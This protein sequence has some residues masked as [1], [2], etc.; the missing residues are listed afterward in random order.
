MGTIRRS[1]SFFDQ[2]SPTFRV[3][4]S[5]LLGFSVNLYLP[6]SM[7]P[8]SM[9][10][11]SILI[12]GEPIFKHRSDLGPGALA[13]VPSPFPRA[14]TESRVLRVPLGPPKGGG[15]NQGHFAERPLPC[16]P[17]P[18]LYLSLSFL[19]VYIYIYLCNYIS[20]SLSISL[21]NIYIYI[22]TYAHIYIYIY[23]IHMHI[24]IYMY[25]HYAYTHICWPSPPRGAEGG[26]VLFKTSFKHILSFQ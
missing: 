18:S 8:E 17:E 10:P 7:L 14:P 25:T 21:S 9:L 5:I 11:E 23:D 2:P 19:Y 22:Y 16:L 15:Q 12:F 26:Q 4:E 1:G 13:L 24:Y 20:L 6:E 3:P